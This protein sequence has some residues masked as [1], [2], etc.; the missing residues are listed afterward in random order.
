MGGSALPIDLIS[1]NILPPNSSR[2]LLVRFLFF[3]FTNKNIPFSD[4]TV[5]LLS[6][7]DIR[8]LWSNFDNFLLFLRT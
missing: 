6:E 5:I 2:Y 1:L 8:K 7:L 3:L 4:L